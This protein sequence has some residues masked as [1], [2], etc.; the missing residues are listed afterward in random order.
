MEINVERVINLNIALTD[1]EKENLNK[2]VKVLNELALNLDDY[3]VC[4]TVADY[5]GDTIHD[6]GELRAFRDI[7]VSLINGDY[8]V[9]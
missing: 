8:G 1:E 9:C 6:G 2:T 5:D 4:L 7:L 3:G